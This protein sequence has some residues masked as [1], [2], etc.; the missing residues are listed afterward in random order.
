MDAEAMHSVGGVIGAGWGAAEVVGAVWGM[1]EVSEVGN[2]E[3]MKSHC[4]PLSGAR[5]DRHRRGRTGTLGGSG[6][7]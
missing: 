1:V 2:E 6:N 3:A 4:Q 7:W 5:S